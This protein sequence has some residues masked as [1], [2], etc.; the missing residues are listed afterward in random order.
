MDSDPDEDTD[1]AKDKK[2]EEVA[3]PIWITFIILAAYT[4]FPA[5]RI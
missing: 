5:L 2:S 1:P 4:L 3:K